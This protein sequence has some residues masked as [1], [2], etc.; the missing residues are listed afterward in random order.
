MLMLERIQLG[1]WSKAEDKILWDGV[2]AYKT[3]QLTDRSFHTTM[4]RHSIRSEPWRVSIS[5][6]VF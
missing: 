5:E 2:E 6:Y 4:H 3:G 1:T